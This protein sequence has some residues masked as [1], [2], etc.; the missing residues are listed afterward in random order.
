MTT[1][2]PNL[3]FWTQRTAQSICA[4]SP[5]TRLSQAM[6]S[7]TLPFSLRSHLTLLK[8]PIR[9]SSRALACHVTFSHSHSNPFPPF[10]LLRSRSNGV[11][12]RP[13]S[14]YVSGPASDPIITEPDPKVESSN[15]VHGETVEPPTAISWSLLWS[16]LMQYKLRLAGSAVALIVCSTCTLSM[17]LFSGKIPNYSI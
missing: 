14:A 2:I 16:L 11:V 9:H 6:A 1:T 15:D 7:A 12:A 4:S 10:S 8:T 17:P 13:P 3:D 5:N